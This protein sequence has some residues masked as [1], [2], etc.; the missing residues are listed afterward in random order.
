[1]GI[2]CSKQTST[3]LAIPSSPIQQTISAKIKLK[4]TPSKSDP[5]QLN[6]SNLTKARKLASDEDIRDFYEFAEILGF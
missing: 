6:Q 1:M 4:S 5:P 3:K 2:K